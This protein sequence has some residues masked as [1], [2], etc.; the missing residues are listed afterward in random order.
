MKLQKPK[1]QNAEVLYELIKNTFVNRRDLLLSCG[2]L[3]APSR[4]DN[5]RNQFGVDVHCE[6]IKVTNKHGRSITYGQWSVSK[7][8]KDIKF[9]KESYDKIN[10][11]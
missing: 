8:V 4:I 6:K 5:L 1:N 10:H 2:V 7:K 3:N 11:D 9:L